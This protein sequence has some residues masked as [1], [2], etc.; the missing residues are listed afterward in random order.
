[1]K[2]S[3]S[4]VGYFNLYSFLLIIVTAAV[5]SM[6][7]ILL[8]FRDYKRDLELEQQAL[9]ERNKNYIETIV[10]DAQSFIASERDALESN[11][12]SLLR[13]RVNEAI[14]TAENIYT[15][16][17]DL[18]PKQEIIN[19]II[20]ALRPI[21]FFNGRG[22]YFAVSM[23]GVEL[24]YPIAPEFEG[25]NVIDLQDSQGT[26]VIQK[27]IGIIEKK[28]EGFVSDFW[29]KPGETRPSKKLTFIKGVPELDMYI[30]TGEYLEDFTQDVQKQITSTLTTNC[31]EVIW[32]NVDNGS[33]QVTV[34]KIGIR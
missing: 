6:L 7:W 3:K 26:Y 8:E 28:G 29:I 32:S 20:E 31:R 22:Y 5:A 2:K 34:Y 14:G 11:V 1:V 24:L 21:R 12:R 9:I 13:D 23:E 19:I 27:E 33:N 30:G 18:L 4:L 25:Q 10:E 16:Y 17:K 15:E